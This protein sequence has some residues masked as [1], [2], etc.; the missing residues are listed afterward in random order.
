MSLQEKARGLRRVTAEVAPGIVR[1]L[2]CE[3]EKALEID[4]LG[5]DA[6]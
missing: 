1:H 3:Y 4:A 5:E 6:V 2:D